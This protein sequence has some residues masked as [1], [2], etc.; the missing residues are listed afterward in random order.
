[1]NLKGH[2]IDSL[3]SNF[4]FQVAP[5]SEARFGSG[6]PVQAGGPPAAVG[7]STVGQRLTGPDP[8]A[9]LLH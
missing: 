4:K 3:T 6:A 2:V 8:A 9:R 7:S 5:K 1:M